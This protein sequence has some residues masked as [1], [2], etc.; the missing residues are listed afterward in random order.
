ME[1]TPPVSKFNLPTHT[2]SAEEL[3]RL[4]PKAKRFGKHSI[5]DLSPPSADLKA[6]IQSY[7][8]KLH[9]DDPDKR[10]HKG[11]VV[12]AIFNE[13]NGH[14]EAFAMAETWC[15]KSKT[16]TGPAALRKY[17]DGLNLKHPNPVTLRTLQWMVEQKALRAS[18]PMTP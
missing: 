4:M 8:D 2:I 3:R 18:T 13:T 6:E 9:P 1:P 12:A 14:L 11:R 10:F 16:Y 17:W 15:K 5:I 7:L